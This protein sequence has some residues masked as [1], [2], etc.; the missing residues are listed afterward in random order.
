MAVIF[1]DALAMSLSCIIVCAILHPFEILR[2]R[3]QAIIRRSLVEQNK[4]ENKPP[5]GEE[6]ILKEPDKN[7]EKNNENAYEAR[8]IRYSA[9]CRMIWAESG[10]DGFFKGYFLVALAHFVSY[11]LFIFIYDAVLNATGIKEKTW[12]I[13]TG[14]ILGFLV[15]PIV[16]P[17]WVTLSKVM[18]CKSIPELEDLDIYW[19]HEQLYIIAQR[20]GWKALWS[21]LRWSCVMGMSN[22]QYALYN[23][24]RDNL[25]EKMQYIDSKILKS[26][27]LVAVSCAA[28]SLGTA[29]QT[30]INTLRTERQLAQRGEQSYYRKE[31][32]CSAYVLWLYHG[33]FIN[34]ARS[35]LAKVMRYGC[36]E[37]FRWLFDIQ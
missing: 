36:F 26:L 13:P 32:K 12:V 35:G 15:Q 37:F 29:V 19:P 27:I 3:K 14:M 7:E 11:F 25:I 33:Y 20:Q 17:L 30:P 21:G 24:I 31:M 8:F 1:S 28:L 16:Q 2:I 22:G 4:A 34:L 6:C 18:A 5:Y 10:I 9:V 23:L